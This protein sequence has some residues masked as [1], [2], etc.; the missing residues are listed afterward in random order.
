MSSR[1][2][3][4]EIMYHLGLS[5]NIYDTEYDAFIPP[6]RAPTWG[7][8]PNERVL[9][10]RGNKLVGMHINWHGNNQLGIDDLTRN[11]RWSPP[12]HNPYTAVTRTA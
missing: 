7:L 3:R 4:M 10:E 6:N 11:W 8:T 2:P 9:L 1:V 12:E 5:Q